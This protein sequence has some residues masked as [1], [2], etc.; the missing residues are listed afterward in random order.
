MSPNAE[1]IY[2]AT[3]EILQ[4]ENGPGRTRQ[5]LYPYDVFAYTQRCVNV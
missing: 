2:I 5:S 4:W 3:I 1:Q